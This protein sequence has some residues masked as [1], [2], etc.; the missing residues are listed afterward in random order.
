MPF[1]AVISY[2]S[3]VG[4]EFLINFKDFSVQ[5]FSLPVVDVSLVLVGSVDEKLGFRDLVEIAR[6]IENFLNKNQVILYYYCDSSDSDVFIRERKNK[7]Q[8]QEF[9][10]RLFDTLFGFMKNNNFV[11]DEIIINDPA[12]TKHYISLITK[13]VDKS[14]LTEVNI[15]VQ[16]MN[17]K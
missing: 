4:S 13:M 16:K 11:K 1:N 5:D 7:L 14:T 3:S 6:I 9:R 12:N 8:P 17:D 10:H 15:A 2:T